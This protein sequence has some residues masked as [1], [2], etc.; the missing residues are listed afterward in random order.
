[1]HMLYFE[2]KHLNKIA[3]ISFFLKRLKIR[4]LRRIYINRL[5]KI[6]FSQTFK[7]TKKNLLRT[8]RTLRDDPLGANVGNFYYVS[9]KL[10]FT[11]PNG[12]I[13]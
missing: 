13:K 6:D 4:M 5:T 10:F 2:T 9:H 12:R 3:S 1:M 8:L 7:M 11:T